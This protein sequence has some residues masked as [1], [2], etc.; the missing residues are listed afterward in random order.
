MELKIETN[1]E[2]TLKMSSEEFANLQL[3][4]RNVVYCVPLSKKV[5]DKARPMLEDMQKCADNYEIGHNVSSTSMNDNKLES[6][7][8]EVRRAAKEFDRND[9]TA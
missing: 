7:W 6:K 9:N 5:I 3:Y 4:L 2:V 8:D 1:V